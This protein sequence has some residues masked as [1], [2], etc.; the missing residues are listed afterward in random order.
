[1]SDTNI[2]KTMDLI[3]DTKVEATLKVEWSRDAPSKHCFLT[4]D[5]YFYKNK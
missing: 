5:K 2:P 1:M 4:T 3:P